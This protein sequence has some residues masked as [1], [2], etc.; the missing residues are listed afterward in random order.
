MSERVEVQFGGS[1]R[2]LDQASAK[3]KQD[4]KSV[5]DTA[6]GLRGVLGQVR[7]AFAGMFGGVSGEA[8]RVTSVMRD[9]KSATSDLRTNVSNLGPMIRAFAALAVAAFVAIAVVITERVVRALIDFGRTMSGL[10]ERAQQTGQMLGMTARQISALNAVAQMSDMSIDQMRS[11]MVRLERSMV[12]AANGGRQQAAAFRT[13]GIDVTRIRNPMEALMQVADRFQ[14]MEDGPR[15]VALAMQLMGRSGAQMIP[16]LNQG[17]EG[18]QRMAGQAEELGAV[19]SREM[20]AAG[21]AVDDAIDEMD[22]GFQGLRNTLFTALAPVIL[23]VVRGL[24]AMIRAMIESYRTGGMMRTVVNALITTLRI[25]GT[26][27]IAVAG[28]AVGAFQAIKLSIDATLGSAIALGRAMGRLLSGDFS[29]AWNEITTHTSNLQTGFQNLRNTAV[30]TGGAIR[31][32]WT[33]GIPGGAT[34]GASG[35]NMDLDLDQPGSGGGGGGGNAAAN[36]AA[37]ERMQ[38]W[39]EEARFRQDLARD[40]FAEQLRIQD[41]IIA[42]VRQFNGQN[43]AEYATEL[44]TRVR[45][46][47]DN[48]DE[49]L[50]IEQDVI[51]TTTRN[52]EAGAEAHRE[53][54]G[55]RLDQ[56][57]DRINQMA[58]LGQI[59]DVERARRL[60]EVLFREYDLEVQHQSQLYEL[61]VQAIRDQLALQG[62]RPEEQRRLNAELLRI[63]EEH[64]NRINVLYRRQQAEIGRANADITRATTA[65]WRGIVEPITSSMNNIFMGLFR[66]TDSWRSMMF[67]ALDSI[68]SHFAQK[69]FEMLT[70]WITMELARTGATAAGAAARTGAETTAAATTGAVSSAAAG[71]QIANNAAVAASG[72]YASTV[73]IPFIG[74]VAAPVAAAVA[75]A[76]V[77][78]FGALIASARGGMDIGA[79]QNPLTQLH[80]K[81]MVLPAHIAEPLR[82]SLRG[83]GP[84]GGPD[85]LGVSAAAGSSTRSDMALRAAEM[86][87]AMGGDIH[88]HALDGKSVERVLKRNR[89]GVARALRAGARDNV[90][91]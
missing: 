79:G 15:K 22:L 52:Q 84:R 41:E 27:V 71:T 76:A 12:Q 74:P 68:V 25:L 7:Q 87:S 45:M 18:L 55:I 9:V 67:Q 40:D 73:M 62:V 21:L 31:D 44:R 16:I 20:V 72:A 34:P 43:S 61:R 50:R 4:I 60:R 53:I 78:G 6:A 82:R 69:G 5:G 83:A 33:G 48:A 30:A 26:V 66:G 38:I 56:E 17:R 14:N 51:T 64:A 88:I 65:R 11:G 75:L 70:N 2:G 32:L 29:G 1:T 80:E 86:A 90:G 59:G 58:E 89:R 3:A 35:E 28:V 47:R 39:L 24:T 42:R 8:A 57:R 85:L 54:S 63:E 36:Q 10:V 49:R 37:Q 19:M 77:L 23:V 81:E 91:G 13:L 46:E